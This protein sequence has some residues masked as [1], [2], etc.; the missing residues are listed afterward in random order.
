MARITLGEIVADYMKDMR[1][2]LANYGIKS[3]ADKCGLSRSF[4]HRLVDEQYDNQYSDKVRN[5][6][7]KTIKMNKELLDY[8]IESDDGREIY[9]KR[10]QLLSQIQGT[11]NKASLEELDVYLNLIQSIQNKL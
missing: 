10:K 8:I 2:D 1:N 3:F 11:C 5:A 9:Y 6:I 4:I 7:S